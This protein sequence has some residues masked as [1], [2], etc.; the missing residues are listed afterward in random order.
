MTNAVDVEGSAGARVRRRKRKRRPR[1]AAELLRL[2]EDLRHRLQTLHARLGLPE[3]GFD[4]IEQKRY[5]AVVRSS[6]EGDGKTRTDKKDYDVGEVWYTTGTEAKMRAAGEAC[7][8][9]EARLIEKVHKGRKQGPDVQGV[10][11]EDSRAVNV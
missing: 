1:S 11:A 8:A 3:P 7:L 2:P 5:R 6:D 9:L 4:V 10:A